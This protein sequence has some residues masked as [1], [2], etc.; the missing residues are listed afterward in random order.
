MREGRRVRG[1][2]G[3]KGSKR[4]ECVFIVLSVFVFVLCVY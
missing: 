4:E 3:E 1:E 2:R